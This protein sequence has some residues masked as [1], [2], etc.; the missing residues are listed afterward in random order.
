[1]KVEERDVHHK[2]YDGCCINS[3]LEFQ[4][5]PKHHVF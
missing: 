1:M 2:K 3:D 4:K 5:L